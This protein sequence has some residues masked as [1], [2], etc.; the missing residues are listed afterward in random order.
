MACATGGMWR[1][2]KYC[3]AWTVSITGPKLFEA[4]GIE[5]HLPPQGSSQSSSRA[6][7]PPIV[8]VAMSCRDDPRPLGSLFAQNTPSGGLQREWNV[9]S[10]VSSARRICGGGGIFWARKPSKSFPSTAVVLRLDPSR[11][12]DGLNG[13][14][15]GSSG[16]L[17]G[18]VVG[19]VRKRRRDLHPLESTSRA[20]ES[21]D[22]TANLGPV[23]DPLARPGTHAVF[24]TNSVL[25][26]CT[27]TNWAP[28]IIAAAR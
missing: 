18:W 16:M 26:S 6:T 1:G 2:P 19:R 3:V 8:C 11:T 23:P 15:L 17:A 5:L 10:V 14:A 25:G 22:V 13:D 24:Q 21:Y 12:K 7:V 28:P 27:H 20:K 4:A 9:P